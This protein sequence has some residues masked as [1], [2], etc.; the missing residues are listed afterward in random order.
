MSCSYQR[1]NRKQRLQCMPTL[2]LLSADPPA[3]EPSSDSCIASAIETRARAAPCWHAQQLS[4]ACRRK[5]GRACEARVV[6]NMLSQTRT[7]ATT[8]VM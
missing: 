2:L 1:L 5:H 3:A 8:E 6:V 4:G 7:A